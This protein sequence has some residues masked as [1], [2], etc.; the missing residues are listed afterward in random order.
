MT[1][2]P[3]HP[4]AQCYLVSNNPPG[5]HPLYQKAVV[6]L[7]KRGTQ[8]EGV[9]ITHPTLLNHDLLASGFHIPLPKNNPMPIL[10]GGPI[11]AGRLFYL[12]QKHDVAKLSERTLK[13]FYQKPTM[14]DVYLG[15]CAWKP[16]NLSFELH[17]GYWEVLPP[18]ASLLT[19]PPSE[20]FMAAREQLGIPTHAY[21]PKRP[22]HG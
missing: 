19:L 16:G 10:M 1:L 21:N 15:Y 9:I 8:T 5:C 18:D 11:K 13:G 17:K 3:I 6:Y 7:T 20:R 14:P 22:A 4:S 2:K 12:N